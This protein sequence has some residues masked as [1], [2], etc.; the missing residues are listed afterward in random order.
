MIYGRKKNGRFKRKPR[1]WCKALM[2]LGAI[3]LLA[4]GLTLGASLGLLALW[5][6]GIP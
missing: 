2:H 4:F 3:C 1:W 6:A 5:L